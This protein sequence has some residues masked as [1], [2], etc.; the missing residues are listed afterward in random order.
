M[1]HKNSESISRLR[2]STQALALKEKDSKLKGYSINV[3]QDV[4]S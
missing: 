3:N 1:Y 4:S 2:I